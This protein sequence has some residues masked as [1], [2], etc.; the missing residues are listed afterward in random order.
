MQGK[1]KR[2]AARAE[3]LRQANLKQF[4]AAGVEPAT[5]SLVVFDDEGGGDLLRSKDEDVIF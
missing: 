4:E 5:E 2:D 1:K 3:E